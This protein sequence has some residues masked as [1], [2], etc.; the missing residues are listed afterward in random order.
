[1]LC[2]YCKS[3]MGKTIRVENGKS[4][5]LYKCPNCHHETKPISYFFEDE[6]ISRNNTKTNKLNS[7]VKKHAKKK[8]GK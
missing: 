4:F 6:K 5:K 8:R 3:L 2:R 1:M 7:P